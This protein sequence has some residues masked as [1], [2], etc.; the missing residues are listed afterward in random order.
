MRLIKLIILGLLILSSLILFSACTPSRIPVD[1][2]TGPLP[3]VPTSEVVQRVVSTP[4]QSSGNGDVPV[5]VDVAVTG[6]VPADIPVME[7]AYQLQAGTSGKNVVYQIDTDIQEV[8]AFYQEELPQFGWE[9]SGPP[10]NA[11]G[12]IGTMLRV[13]AEGDQLAI[14]MQA[15]QLGGFVKLTITIARGK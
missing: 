12:S 8:L 13:N 6:E 14:N 1:E 15:N 11:I 10:D 4:V 7:A 2:Y 5:N 9:L 3:D